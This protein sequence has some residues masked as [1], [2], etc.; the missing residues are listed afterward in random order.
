[1]PNRSGHQSGRSDGCSVS[2]DSMRIASGT[3]VLRRLRAT[4]Q[5]RAA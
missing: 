1:M 5:P 3:A 2:A 4:A